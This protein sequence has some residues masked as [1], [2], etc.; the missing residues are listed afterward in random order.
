MEYIKDLNQNRIEYYANEYL[1]DKEKE[2]NNYLLSS[3]EEDLIA[4]LEDEKESIL[5][6]DGDY[7]NEYVDSSLSV[8]TYDQIM[9]FAHNSDL[10]HMSS[11]MGGETVQEQIV[12]V[13]DE[14]LSGVAYTWLHEK[15]EEEIKKAL[16]NKAESQGA[17]K[18]VLE[19]KLEVMIL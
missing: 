19:K 9:I 10:W 1:K 4:C 12:G 8:Y 11:G 13:I 18:E 7:I 16:I 5:E 14:H 6:N 2:K 17:N 15:Q 3:I